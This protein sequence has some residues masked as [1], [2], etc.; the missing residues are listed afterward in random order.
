MKGAVEAL[1]EPYVGTTGGL[2]NALH[3]IQHRDGYVDAAAVPAIAEVFNLTKAEVKGVISFYEDFRTKPMG[4][5]EVRICQAEACQAVGARVLTTSATEK[6]S[7]ELGETTPCERITL[8]GVACLGLCGVAPAVEVDGV[9]Y[10]RMETVEFMEML[11]RLLE[12][13]AS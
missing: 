12:A 11:G 9:P 2:I 10:G 8:S 3:A 13:P 1:I 4:N 5:V 7:I 6:L